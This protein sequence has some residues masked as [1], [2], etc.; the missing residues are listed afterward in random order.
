MTVWRRSR[1]C[2]AGACVEVSG[3]QDKVLI[4]DSKDPDGPVLTFT[5]GFWEWLLERLAAGETVSTIVPENGGMRWWNQIDGW[6]Y[7]DFTGEEWDTFVTGVR[8]G[9]FDLDRL[10]GSVTQ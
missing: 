2:E 9:E 10:A 1:R 7:L 8:D 5:A 6:V 4:R 3:D